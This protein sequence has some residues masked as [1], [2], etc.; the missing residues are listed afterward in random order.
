MRICGIDPGLRITGYAVIEAEGARV[1]LIEAGVVRPDKGCTL[2]VRLRQLSLEVHDVFRE[3]KPDAIAVEK[4]YSHYAHPVTAILMGHARGVILAAAAQE[5]IDLVD[6]S[7]TRIKKLLTG[8]GHASKMQMQGA[9][10]HVL[11]LKATPEPPDVADA[12]AIALAGWRMRAG[13][14]L[15][16]GSGKRASR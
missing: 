3:H 6:I 10:M 13:E 15:S 5:H 12:I 1:K 14:H 11:N 9:V 2:P 7:A 4:L 8:N 16:R